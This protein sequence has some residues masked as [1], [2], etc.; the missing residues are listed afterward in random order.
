MNGGESGRL[1]LP[2][3]T[4]DAG[5]LAA[6]AVAHDSVIAFL[7]TTRP[8]DALRFYRDVLDLAFIEETP[9]AI[10]LRS[11]PTMI[12]IQKVDSLEPR[13][14]TALGWAVPDLLARVA[15]LVEKG[16]R[17]ERFDGFH[18]D[19]FAVWTAPDG[20]MV[21][22]FRDPDGNLLSHTQFAS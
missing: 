6:G 4:H 11:G 15:S 14:D 17:F 13:S 20:T 18:Q 19:P 1:H 22:W 9:F 7:A 8:A 10:A 21:A 3:E 12:R 16:V 2:T 5:T